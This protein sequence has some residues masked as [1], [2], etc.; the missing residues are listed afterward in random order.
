MSA[1]CLARTAASD[2][3]REIKV[4]YLRALVAAGFRH[5]DAVSFVSPKHVRAD[6]RQRSRAC[7]AILC[8]ACLRGEAPEIIGIV[9]NEK[10]IERALAAPGVTTLG[11]PYSISAYFRRANAN[12]SRAESRALVE[13][14]QKSDE[15]CRARAGGVHL[16]GVRQSVRGAVGTGNRRGHAGLAERYR[17]ANRFARRY[18][19]NRHARRGGQAVLTPSRIASRVSRWACICTAG[20]RN[21]GK[22]YG[23]LQCRLPPIR[24]RAHRAGRLPVRRRRLGRQHRHRDVFSRRLPC[25]AYRPELTAARWQCFAHG[26]RKSARNTPRIH[27]RRRI[28]FRRRRI[29]T[30][31]LRQRMGRIE[32]HMAYTTLKLEHTGRDRHHHPV[33]PGTAQ[34]DLSRTD[35]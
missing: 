13:Q 8:L 12:M 4:E 7:E 22:S 10:G 14:L 5:I 31:V 34:R 20:P 30:R 25:A 24:F 6:G 3:R 11:Y 18:G 1:R 29:R 32:K 27:P 19:R 26:A 15:R 17:R 9:V 21:R 23:R 33:T 16:H 2:S 28:P 35:G